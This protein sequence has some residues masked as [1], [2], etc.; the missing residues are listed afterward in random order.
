MKSKLKILKFLPLLT[1]GAILT[2]CQFTPNDVGRG[3][4]GVIIG[5]GVLAG[6]VMLF[7]VILGIV[8]LLYKGKDVHVKIVKKKEPKVLR[9]KTNNRGGATLSRKAR[10]EKGRI[11]YSKITVELDG[12]T[13]TLKCSDIVIFDKLLVGRIQ[14]IRIRFGEII[15]ILK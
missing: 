8:S 1:L 11:R 14:K 3:Y 13:K 10:R 15:K 6:A 9:D 2:G 4:N 5:I 12:E 7:F